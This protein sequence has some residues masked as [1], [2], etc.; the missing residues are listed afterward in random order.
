MTYDRYRQAIAEGKPD[1]IRFNQAWFDDLLQR[2]EERD[3]LMASRPEGCWC[4]GL[5][6]HQGEF[7]SCPEGVTARATDMAQRIREQQAR[8]DVRWASKIPVR[9]QEFRLDSSPVQKVANRMSAHPG[10]SWFLWGKYGVG[11]TG[12]AVGYARMCCFEEH[13]QIIFRSV[14]DL[15]SELRSTYG[16]NNEHEITEADVI[17]Q[18]TDVEL[19]VLDDLGAEQVKNQDWVADRLYQIV[20]TRHAEERPTVFTSNLSPQEVGDRIGERITWRIVEMV[21]KD[22]IVEVTGPNL[23]E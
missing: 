16:R 1:R 4:L 17:V 7:C 2:C 9:F 23:R 5:G 22:N 3:T 20:G 18:Y 14:P 6:V 10:K 19:L 11:K 8:L 15:L 21:G 12:L 13:Y